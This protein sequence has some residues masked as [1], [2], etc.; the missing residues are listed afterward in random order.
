MIADFVALDLVE[1]SKKKH[2]VSD[3]S[4]YWTLTKLGKQLNKRSRRIQLEEGIKTSIENS[5]DENL[6]EE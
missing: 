1:P 5:E 4:L 3:K 2:P 6:A